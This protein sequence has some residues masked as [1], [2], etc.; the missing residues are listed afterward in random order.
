MI[1]RS[2]EPHAQVYVNGRSLGEA[3][4][5]LTELPPGDH[6]VGVTK[7]GLK[8]WGQVVK[9]GSE[10][11]EVWAKLSAKLG[12]ARKGEMVKRGF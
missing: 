11:V 5:R 2:D 12:G 3:P 9:V 6:V 4:I 7:A 1:I 8:S 10:P